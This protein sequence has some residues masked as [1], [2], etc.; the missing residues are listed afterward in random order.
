M[1]RAP[2]DYLCGIG[3]GNKGTRCR[4]ALALKALP[5]K[6]WP[7]LC[8]FERHSRLYAARRTFGACLRTRQTSCRRPRTRF[9]SGARPL[10]LTWFTALR[11]VL[12]L[13]V[14]EKELFPGGEDKLTTTICAG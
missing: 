11:V 7:S 8:R 2:S 12:E 3:C 6:Y 5:A 9:Q 13:L 10:G 14:E 1:L 4:R